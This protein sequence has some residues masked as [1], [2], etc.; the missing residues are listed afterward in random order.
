MYQ[1]WMETDKACP[2]YHTFSK[3]KMVASR[4]SF[5]RLWNKSSWTCILTSIKYVP[6]FN[7]NW[8][9]MS[10]I[11]HI[12]KN[13]DDRQSAIIDP[14]AKQIVMDMYP[15]IYNVCT[16]F[17]QKLTKHVQD[18]THFQKSRWLP[19]SHLWSDWETNYHV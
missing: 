19:V 16:K 10:R 11:P 1:V 15:N 4:P 5:F 3:N 12:F 17:K 13:Q 14:I 6:N 8:Q 7:E 9:S 2:R 18:T